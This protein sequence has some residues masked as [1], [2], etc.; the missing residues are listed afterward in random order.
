MSALIE[1][2]VLHDDQPVGPLDIA[3]ENLEIFADSL[4][5][6]DSL[7]K[8]IDWFLVLQ[9]VLEDDSISEIEKL[10]TEEELKIIEN[11]WSVLADT[12]FE[13]GISA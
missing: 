6:Q 5:M 8:L 4:I 12:L 1:G 13:K 11:A 9:Q 10:Q 7:K 3:R 2:K